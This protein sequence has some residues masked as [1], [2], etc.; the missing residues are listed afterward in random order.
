MTRAHLRAG[1]LLLL[2]VLAG[3]VLAAV[4]LRDATGGGPLGLGLGL[5]GSGADTGTLLPGSTADDGIDP[6]RY[7]PALRA[8]REARAT[9][10]LAH[11]LYAKSPG[12]AVL[13]ARRVDALRPKVERAA[14]AGG[15]D[16]DVLEGIVFLESAGR[17]DAI[18]D[19]KDLSGAAGLTQILAET[20][21]NLLD[22][23]IDVGASTKLTRGIARGTKVA[24]R[25]RE[26]R[27]VDERFD[28]DKALAATV[29]YLQF[30]KDKLGDNLELAVVSYHMGVGNLQTVLKK[31]GADD[32][33]YAQLYFGTTPLDHSKAY[34]FLTGLGD[35]SSTYLW[36]VRAAEAIMARYRTDPDALARTAALQTRKNSAEEVLH[37]EGSVPAY[38]DPFALGR[39]EA[40][41][42]LKRLDRD[43]LASYGLV[44]SPAMGELAPKLKQSRRLYRAVRPE[45]LAV[46]LYLGAAAQG[47]SGN[48]PL[49][50]TS[51]IRDRTYQRL[52]VRRNPEATK[53]YSLHTTGYTFDIARQ[54]VSKAQSQAF[55]FGL[56]RLTALNIIA[57]VREPGAIHVT[58]SQDV[59]EL[60]GLL[61]DGAPVPPDAVAPAKAKAKAGR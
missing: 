24:A 60:L 23:R 47:I 31:Y 51:T 27:R 3:A 2:A 5:G 19:S 35:D 49:V 43:Q 46:L 42:E 36:R 1:A 57:W 11:V 7:T 59:P 50:V 44:I 56:D 45:A 34:G 41:G 52:L 16:A 48:G 39:A 58:V 20:G 29:R 26:R 37:P 30:A 61:K 9:A 25:R 53:A 10:G 22:M 40:G 55:Q 17:P 18:A 14:Q 28:P 21:E 54:Y 12:G 4:L 33:A 6:L 32:V 15:V 38:P 13:T 8:D